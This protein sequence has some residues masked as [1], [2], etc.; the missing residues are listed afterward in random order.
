MIARENFFCSNHSIAFL[1]SEYGK[2]ETK[3][4]KLSLDLKPS[5]YLKS[6]FCRVEYFASEYA[7]R[8]LSTS[9]EMTFLASLHKNGSNIPF[10]VPISKTMSSFLIS[11]A[12]AI[13]LATDCEIKKC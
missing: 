12:A 11:A 10:P 13:V 2:F 6:R 8:F 1:L 4:E 9:K 3:T 7:C 5:P